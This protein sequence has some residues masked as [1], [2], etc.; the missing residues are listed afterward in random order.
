M[1]RDF[2]HD[3]HYHKYLQS[4]PYEKNT[5]RMFLNEDELKAKR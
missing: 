5:A 1:E 3:A 4:K 2:E